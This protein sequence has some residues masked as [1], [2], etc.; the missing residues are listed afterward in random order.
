MNI[1]EKIQSP[2]AAELNEVEREIK[3]LVASDVPIV[4]EIVD[5]VTLH[6]GKRLR[7]ILTLFS[8][9]MTGGITDVSIKSAAL[10]ELLHSATLIHDDVIDV[11][12]LRRGAPSVNAVWGN[13][14][15]IL[16]GDL[17]YSRVLYRL[18]HIGD[19]EITN[20]V[21][22][23]IKR[24]CEGELIQLQN[25]FD[26]GA[27]GEQS[28]LDLIN[29]KTA[30]LL[31]V[32]CELGA[33]SSASHNGAAVR[34]ALRRF[35]EHIGMAFQIKDD[36]MD[37]IGTQESIGKPVAHDII[38]QTLT[39]PL[40]YGL[41]NV[42]N[43]NRDKV[44]AILRDGIGEGD[45]DTIH[46]F[47]KESGGIEYAERKAREFCDEALSNLTGFDDSVYKRSLVR[48]AGFIVD[49]TY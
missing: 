2:I 11:S 31:A 40:L 19:S 28:Y 4:N 30:S 44:L 26:Y 17:F 38:E 21:S 45:I 49:R 5:H 32:A 18:A 41:K 29:K 24:I 34:S 33:L 20:I 7:P 35:G 6:R 47:V 46:R 22:L 36:V 39:L 13:K 48:L 15:S 14:V 12:D 16:I 9:G 8:S 25:G 27:I 42:E 1:L 43:G 10:V 3:T 37:I 23:A